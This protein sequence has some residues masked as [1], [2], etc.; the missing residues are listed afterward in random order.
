[1]E[2]FYLGSH[3][4][5][6][7]GLAEVPLMVSQRAL[8]RRPPRQRARVPWALDSGAFSEIAAHG[9]FTTGPRDYTAAVRR[10]SDEIGN[11]AWAAPQDWM[12]EPVVLSGGLVGGQRFAG[13]HLSVAEHQR[14]TV[15]SLLELRTLAPDLPW[16]PV[17]QGWT[18]DDYGRCA[19][20]YLRA[21]IDLAAEPLV[22]LGSVCR[23]Q[24]TTE[25]ER[26]VVTLAGQGLRLHGFGVKTAGLGRYGWALESADSLAWSYAARREPPLPGHPHANCANCLA[27]A[28]WWRERVLRRP[29]GHQQLT[30]EV[31]A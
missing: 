23:R 1:M 9:K 31:A 13:T 22:G 16:L 2:T 4:P 25:I 21:G 6:W 20:A 10:W 15:A 7:L 28:L 5:H 14:R 26:I 30:L 27:Y 17:L 29:F 11:L 24:A 18:L 12:C 8:V 19:D 3:Q